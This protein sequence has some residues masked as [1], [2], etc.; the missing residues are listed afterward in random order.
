MS[1]ILFKKPFGCKYKRNQLVS[2]IYFKKWFWVP[3]GFTQRTRRSLR[4]LRETPLHHV[5]KGITQSSQKGPRPARMNPFGRAQRNTGGFTPNSAMPVGLAAYSLRLAA[6]LVQVLET[7][8]TACYF[9]TEVCLHQFNPLYSF[10]VCP[11]CCLK[12]RL[13]CCGYL[14]PK[15]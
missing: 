12:K 2:Q 6:V 10:G 15:S 1:P 11:T 5:V 13:K 9:P 3:P 7:P 14:K 8:T 4:P